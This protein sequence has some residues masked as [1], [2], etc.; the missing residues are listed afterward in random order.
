M[1]EEIIRN[2]WSQGCIIKFN[3]IPEDDVLCKEGKLG[4]KTLLL[5]ISQS[6]DV[7]NEGENHVECLVLRFIKAKSFRQDFTTG[8]N[9]RKLHIDY[10]GVCYEIHAYEFVFLKKKFLVENA[11]EQGSLLD[12][13]HLNIVKSFKANRYVRTGLPESA[14]KLIEHSVFK[15]EDLKTIL[16][17][18]GHTLHSIRVQVIE[19]AENKFSVAVI[20]L[21]K[22]QY[23]DDMSPYWEEILEKLILTPMRHIPEID[24]LDVRNEYGLDDVMNASEFGIELAPKF[25]RFFYD[26]LSMNPEGFDDVS[27][28]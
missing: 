18:N 3:Q 1:R 21:V 27:D 17:E 7:V 19:L 6:C 14:A 13:E 9:P 4:E 5:V 28:E 22:Q 26:A 15:S 24:L 2:G 8:L 23:F 20:M 10:K 11:C 25:P 12:D 16:S